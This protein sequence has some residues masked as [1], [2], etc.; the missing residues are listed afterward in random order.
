MSCKGCQASVIVSQD[1]IEQLV[2]EQLQFEDDIVTNEVYEKRLI[3]CRDCPSLM[4]DTTC[5]HCGCFVQF[6]AKLA[7]K[8]CPFPSG[9]KW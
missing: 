7:Y 8:S 5:G 6:R 9:E 2:M 1:E 4:Y 3:T